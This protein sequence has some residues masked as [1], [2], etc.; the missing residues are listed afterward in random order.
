MKDTDVW[1]TLN[2]GRVTVSGEG[3]T[4]RHP[5]FSREVMVTSHDG[6]DNLVYIRTHLHDCLDGAIDYITK[7]QELGKKRA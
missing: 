1:F 2:V 7:M 5:R 3:I 6:F 4:K